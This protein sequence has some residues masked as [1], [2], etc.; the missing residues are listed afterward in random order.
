[1]NQSPSDRLEQLAAQIV[2]AYIDDRDTLCSWI[3]RDQKH[4]FRIEKNGVL[5]GLGEVKADINEK[6]RS[7]QDA[8]QKNHKFPS[9]DKLSSWVIFVNPKNNIALVRAHADLLVH[10]INRLKINRFANHLSFRQEEAILLYLS[11]KLGVSQIYRLNG[12]EVGWIR[13][14]ESPEVHLLPEKCPPV[15]DWIS[16]VIKRFETKE[17]VRILAQADIPEKHFF[18]WL[19]NNSPLE[20]QLYSQNFNHDVPSDIPDLPDW[21]THLWVGAGYVFGDKRLIWLFTREGGWQ[22]LPDVN[23]N[24]QY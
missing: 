3:P 6:H 15:R 13:L 8:I 16:S 2:S 21:L 24:P 11:N 14:S 23:I 7:F 12:T 20:L 18:I 19:H 10:E 5:L 1:M 22:L 17:E 4:D 9:N